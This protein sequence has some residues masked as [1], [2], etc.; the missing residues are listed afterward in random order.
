MSQRPAWSSEIL[1]ASATSNLMLIT[2]LRHC[3]KIESWIHNNC[4]KHFLQ[5][6]QFSEAIRKTEI[7]DQVQNYVRIALSSNWSSFC[8]FLMLQIFVPLVILT[9]VFSR[10]R[11]LSKQHCRWQRLRSQ[12]PFS[13]AQQLCYYGRDVMFSIVHNPHHYGCYLISNS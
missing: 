7:Y 9:L 11:V 8:V 2:N 1:F 4:M 12:I 6:C 5:Q 13:P 10:H 3:S